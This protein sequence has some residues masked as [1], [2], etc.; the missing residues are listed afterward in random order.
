MTPLKAPLLAPPHRYAMQRT[1][2]FAARVIALLGIGFISMFALDVLSMEAP[3]APRLAGFLVHLIPSFV[4]AGLLV[5]AWRWPGVG[6]ALFLIAGLS[7]LL[8][9]DNP[10]WTNLIL[11]GPFLLAGAGFLAGRS[12]GATSPEPG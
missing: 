5:V 2:I 4:L 12:G 10:L 3:L 8:L 1:L 7:P 9:L 6:G 11:G